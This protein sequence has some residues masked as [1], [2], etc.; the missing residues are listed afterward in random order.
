MKVLKKIGKGLCIALA[1]VLALALLVVGGLNVAKFFIYSDYYE[2]HDNLC[3]NPGLW[4]GFIC[5]G[6]AVADEQDVVLVSGYMDGDG[7][8]R[9][10]VTTLDNDSYYVELLSEGQEFD[11]H[12]GGISVAAG[13][14][15]VATGSK[16]YSCSLD[17]VLNAKDG[18]DVEI[19]PGVEINNRASYLYSDGEYLYVGAFYKDGYS[20]KD[21][22]VFETAE[23]THSAICT[24]YAV[25]DLTTPVA[26]YSVR[27][28][29][30]GICFTP[31]GDVVMST[32]YGLA[33]SYY[34]VYEL[35]DAVDS[36]KTLDGAPVYFLDNVDEVVKGPAMA[37]GLDYYKG[38][39]I[40]L[41]ESASNKYIY[42][43]LFFAY[44][45]VSLDI[46]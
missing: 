34:Y 46:D 8:S 40:T 24:K 13:Q 14:V 42:G 31:D 7:A 45:I 21:E 5:Q 41:T 2:M 36:G 1:A 43:K 39:V 26:I 18:D 37:E 35:E 10:Y 11:G 15:F 38:N 29:V 32:S 25:D 17:T 20:F 6:I 30:Q 23:G 19:G 4:D 27:D 16:I 12:V 44:Y 33:D 9:I 28:K 3:V 22:H